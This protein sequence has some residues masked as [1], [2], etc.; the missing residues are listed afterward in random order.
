MDVREDIQWPRDRRRYARVLRRYFND[1][2]ERWSDEDP[3]YVCVRRAVSSNGDDAADIVDLCGDC[4]GV[5]VEHRSRSVRAGVE[6]QAEVLDRV[7]TNPPVDF[8][9]RGGG[10]DFLRGE[11][12]E[13]CPPLASLHCPGGREKGD[14]EGYLAEQL[15]AG[16]PAILADLL[17]LTIHFSHAVARAAG[18]EAALPRE[19]EI[20]Q[21]AGTKKERRRPRRSRRRRG[22][23]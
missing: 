3:H 14:I 8:M 13:L 1:L 20:Q 2:V 5:L 15:K 9:G 23:V 11:E 4:D 7:L 18:L 21:A 19:V 6:I 17:S 12:E 10:G 22:T 16:R